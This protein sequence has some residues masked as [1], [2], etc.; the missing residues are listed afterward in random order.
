MPAHEAPTL[1]DGHGPVNMDDAFAKGL[2]D[3]NG[4]PQGDWLNINDNPEAADIAANMADTTYAV[5]P[6]GAKEMAIYTRNLKFVPDSDIMVANIKDGLIQIPDGMSPEEAVNIARIQSLNYGNK[7]L[8]LMLKDCDGNQY[9]LREVLKNIHDN[10]WTTVGEGH[11]LGDMKDFVG[12]NCRHGIIKQID[13][14]G[15]VKIKVINTCKPTVYEGTVPQHQHPQGSTPDEPTTPPKSDTSNKQVDSIDLNKPAPDE[16]SNNEFRHIEK[17]A[18][19][20]SQQA[21]DKTF[22][23]KSTPATD[24]EIKSTPAG[25]VDGVKTNGKGLLLGKDGKPLTISFS[26]NSGG[27]P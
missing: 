9:D 3:A 13:C 16:L 11:N 5:E 12:D 26:H 10:S 27:R 8:L 17:D 15:N 25:Q 19:N 20:V 4:H 22:K 14:D 2:F 18:D 24:A 21:G 23:L 7:D 1:G 6:A